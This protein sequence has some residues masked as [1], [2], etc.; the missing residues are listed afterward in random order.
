VGNPIWGFGWREAHRFGLTVAVSSVE[1]STPVRVGG[2]RVSEAGEV[3]EVPQAAVV[4]REVKA[5]PGV[6][7]IGLVPGK[8]SRP[9]K[10]VGGRGEEA[11]RWRE[12]E[13]KQEGVSP[14]QSRAKG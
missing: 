13:S 2:A 6:G 7:C 1:F 10:A 3:R 14:L 5:R 11:A 4:L 9:R 8:S 12:D